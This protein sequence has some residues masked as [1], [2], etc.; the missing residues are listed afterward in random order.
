[1]QKGS[2]VACLR[3]VTFWVGLFMSCCLGR[4]PAHWVPLQWW[5]SVVLCHLVMGG[6]QKPEQCHHTETPQFITEAP[7]R[8]WG[9]E[10]DTSQAQT[11][12]HMARSLHSPWLAPQPCPQNDI[13]VPPEHSA[14][15]A[16]G[17]AEMQGMGGLMLS[18]G[19]T[20]LLSNNCLHLTKLRAS[21]EKES[22]SLFASNL[23]FSLISCS[24]T[25]S[26]DP[27]PWSL[28]KGLNNSGHPKL[29][30]WKWQKPMLWNVEFC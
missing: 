28:H 16:L 17:E 18:H 2:S 27:V 21:E 13:S 7:D 10:P 30:C 20:D 14:G 11:D 23:A 15:L 12:L 1:M 26:F 9:A 5:Q 25:L 4:C 24:Y 19:F 8:I 6:L 22:H 3:S 29:Q